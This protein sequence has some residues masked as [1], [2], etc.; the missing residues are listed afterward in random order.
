VQKEQIEPAGLIERALEIARPRLDRSRVALTVSAAPG[1]PRIEADAVQLEL[2]LLNLVTNAIDAMGEGGS[3]D[4]RL[5]TTGTGVRLEVADSG[6]GIPEAM[7]TSIFE[8]W[9]TTK[10]FGRG[11]GL[12][13]AIARSV[14]GAHGGTISVA[15]RPGGGALFTV[16]LPAVNSPDGAADPRPENE[17][18]RRGRP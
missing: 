8:P 17:A 12:G 5:T 2:A 6:P 18:R 3:L 11:T 14:I 7:L 4:V 9:V 13:L 10:P 1:L 16:D 15:N